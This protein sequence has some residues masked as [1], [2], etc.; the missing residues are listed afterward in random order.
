MRTLV[1]WLLTGI[2]AL[3]L[4]AIGLAIADSLHT[5]TCVAGDYRGHVVQIP[6]ERM[7]FV[8][9]GGERLLFDTVREPFEDPQYELHPEDGH[10]HPH[11]EEYFEVV[12]GSARFL[13]GDRE[14]V[15]EPGDKAVVPPNTVHHW[16]ALNGAPVRVMAEF[17][18]AL[19]TAD[20]FASFHGHLE[21]GDMNLLQAVVIQSEFDDGAPWPAQA[22][23]LWKIMVK[24]LAPVG[25]MMGYEAC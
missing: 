19:D 16:M 5:K 2:G 6:G 18:P 25:R 8:E 10:V 17:R 9:T 13:I 3:L 24:V 15:L 1:R 21:R 14:V 7:A 12:T 11:Q 20:W 23:W 4:T 22:E